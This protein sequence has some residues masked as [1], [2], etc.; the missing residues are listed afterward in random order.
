[1]SIEATSTTFNRLRELPELLQ[2]VPERRRPSVQ[3]CALVALLLADRMR[4]RK[5]YVDETVDQ[6]L[7][8][9]PLSKATVTNCL[10]ALDMIGWW[11]RQAKGNHRAGTRRTPAVLTEHGEAD[12]T[13]QH[14]GADPTQPDGEHREVGDAASLGSTPSIVRYGTQHREADLTT[15]HH[16][17]PV[18][19]TTSSS[20]D[21]RRQ[22]RSHLA[23]HTAFDPFLKID[24]PRSVAHAEFP[25]ACAI[26]DEAIEFGD[27]PLDALEVVYPT[28]PPDD[29]GEFDPGRWTHQEVI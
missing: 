24:N 8:V 18:T 4:D 28:R 3:N 12:L 29:A 16:P 11:T 6:I 7:D 22:I 21:L 25:N 2:S 15:P 1:V 10:Y 14:D 9:L 26:A 17:H 19:P 13:M 5:G 20:P 23:A 27:D